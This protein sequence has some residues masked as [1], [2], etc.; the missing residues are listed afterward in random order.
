MSDVTV[1]ARWTG[2]LRFEAV[3]RADVPMVVD[4][5]GEAGPTPVESLAVGLAT[6]MGADVV[7]ILTKMRVPFD[8]LSVRVDG[9]RRE[10]PPRRY[11]ALRLTYD[12]TGVAE[13]SEPK[14]RRA[15]DLSRDKYC[16]VLH[17]LRPDLEVSVRI[18][19]G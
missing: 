18:E 13:E 14:L 8:E 3:G 11:T 5:D 4:G 16:S 6:C 17:S 10:E 2:G 15:V 9:D 7:D 19:A 12:V 1:R